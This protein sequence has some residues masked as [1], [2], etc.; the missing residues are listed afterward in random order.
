MDH[1]DS[2]FVQAG[3]TPVLPAKSLMNAPDWFWGEEERRQ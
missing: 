2:K 3:E 1:A